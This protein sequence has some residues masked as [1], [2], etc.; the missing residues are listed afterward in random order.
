MAIRVFTD[1]SADIPKELKDEYNI[2]DVPLKI[3]FG[4]EEFK[5]GVE[6]SAADFYTKLAG[7]SVMPST[8]QPS[9]GEFIEAYKAHSQPQD[10]IISVHLSSELSGTFQ[11]ANLASSMIN[12][13]EI[14]VIDGRNAS[15][16]TGM[17]ALAA[18]GA[19]AQGKTKDEIVAL[20]KRIV[21]NLKVYFVVETLEYLHKNGR[22]GKAAALVGGLLKIKPILCI[23][24]GV[25]APYAKARGTKRALSQM[26]AEVAQDI[27]QFKKETVIF[28]VHANNEAGAK[29]LVER[30]MQETNCP[31]PSVAVVG[32]VIGSHAGPNTLGVLCYDAALLE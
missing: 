8:S 9:P 21:S 17:I 1:S 27:S 5:D 18:A 12:D 25:V 26:V 32:P 13:R 29:D 16:G 20:C 7:S 10:T 3:R 15:V 14:I 4:D 19:A 30:L 24:D 28:V 22:I 6:L 2:V 11:S 31:Q 23:D